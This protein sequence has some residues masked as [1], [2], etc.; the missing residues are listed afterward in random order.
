MLIIINKNTFNEKLYLIMLDKYDIDIHI[1]I[2]KVI[3]IIEINTLREVFI[4][5]LE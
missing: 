2:E 1:N 3:N 5:S 4:F